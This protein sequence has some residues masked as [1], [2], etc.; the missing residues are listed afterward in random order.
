MSV[1]YETCLLEGRREPTFHSP[2]NHSFGAASHLPCSI[3][4]NIVHVCTD[5]MLETIHAKLIF[6]EVLPLLLSTSASKPS[7]N[8]NFRNVSS[9]VYSPF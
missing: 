7:D 8:F 2:C 5:V 9:Y 6:K 1:S 4:K 3:E